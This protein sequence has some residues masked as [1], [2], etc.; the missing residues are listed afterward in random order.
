LTARDYASFTIQISE[1]GTGDEVAEAMAQLC[2][3]TAGAVLLHMLD[4]DGR[5]LWLEG[6]WN[7]DPVVRKAYKQLPVPS[8]ALP[9]CAALGQHK[10][11]QCSAEAVLEMYPL[12][13]ALLHRIPRLDIPAWEITAIPI[14]RQGIPLGG[15]TIVSTWLAGLVNDDDIA[16]SFGS[17]APWLA[18]RTLEP[19]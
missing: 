12:S 7:L 15:I 9:I 8:D 19:F 18:R 3:L 4:G 11:L 6:A 2:E 17:V 10:I 13:R 14:A 16:A 1:A 5:T